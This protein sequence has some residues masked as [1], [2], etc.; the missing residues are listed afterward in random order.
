MKLVLKNQVDMNKKVDNFFK[1]R[2]VNH[3]IE[4]SEETWSK[5]FRSGLKK[6]RSVVWLRAAAAILVIVL[7]GILS[8]YVRTS[9][10]DQTVTSVTSTQADNNIEMEEN[11]VLQEETPAKIIQTPN[12]AKPQPTETKANRPLELNKN[13]Q[14]I[15]EVNGTQVMENKKTTD[16]EIEFTTTEVI[17]NSPTVTHKPIVIVYE[18]KPIAEYDESVYTA[19]PEK[20]SGIKKV[21]EAAS[22]VRSGESRLMGLRQAKEEILAFNFK[23]E[24][25]NN[26]E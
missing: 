2:L 19:V 22:D 13:E 26:N 10:Y 9:T 8:L 20:K 23:K 17:E 12:P 1:E 7:A 6:N 25:K 11:V 21:L 4:P 18:L 15:A 16:S 24:E 3:A 5:I 14:L